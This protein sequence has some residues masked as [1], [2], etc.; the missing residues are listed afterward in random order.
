V[1][2]VQALM[3]ELLD[4]SERLTRAAL[5]ELPDGEVSFEDW[6]DDDGIDVGKPIRLFVT[7]KKKGDHMVADW[8]GTSPQV[9]GAINNTFSYTAA[10]TYTGIKSVLSV[11]MP[12][13]DGVF[14]AIEVVAPP[15]TVANGVLPAACAARGLTGFRMLDCMFGA[16]AMLVPDRVFASSDGGN[17]GVTIGGYDAQRKPFIYVD[18]MSGSW[19][20]RPW[21]DGIEGN[22]NMFANMASQPI[23]VLE[24]EHPIQILRYEFVTDGGGAGKHR[25]GVPYRRDYRFLEAEAILQVRSDRHDH[26]PYGLHGGQ[27]G[28]PSQNMLDP[29]GAQRVL[30]P[31][32]TMTIT[33]GTV[34]RHT[35][36]GSGGW[37]DP[38]E[39]EPAKVLADVRNEFVSVAAAATEYGVVINPQTW[40]VDDAATQRRRE[41]MRAQRGWTEPPAVVREVEP[42]FAEA[43]E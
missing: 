26:R 23:E 41:R 8:T 15:G 9:R 18:F 43:A 39:R 21:A 34:Y 38:L 24:T 7:L 3:D 16:L 1:R 11:N 6:I 37:G 17:T 32:L 25:G 20:G 22:A 28:K 2:G 35:L 4:Y 27:P 40:T 29:D 33:R 12:N 19:G 10:A 13:N 31:K 42:V 30:D 14:R 5:Q 36:P